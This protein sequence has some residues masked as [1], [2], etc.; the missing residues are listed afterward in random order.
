MAQQAALNPN[1]GLPSEDWKAR[2]SEVPM[3]EKR[4]QTLLRIARSFN[5]LRP[6]VRN[7]VATFSDVSSASSRS[8][9]DTLVATPEDSPCLISESYV[10]MLNSTR[11]HSKHHPLDAEPAKRATITILDT[12]GG[13]NELPI[14]GA[15]A[16]SLSQLVVELTT[17]IDDDLLDDLLL[18]YR[19][20]ATPLQ[21]GRALIARFEWALK[22]TEDEHMVARVRYQAV[23]A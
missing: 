7:S 12:S 21:L 3:L 19:I 22:G 2:L 8:T 9:F 14:L 18:T 10:D 11:E 4:K 15:W 6:A 13:P 17:N 20:F 1:Q 5:N 23:K 16:L